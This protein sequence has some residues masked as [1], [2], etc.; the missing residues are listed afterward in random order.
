[1][2]T[3]CH[4]RLFR[5]LV[6][7]IVRFFCKLYEVLLKI[8]TRLRRGLESDPTAILIDHL[9]PGQVKAQAAIDVGLTRPCTDTGE[10]LVLIPFRD[11]WD[12]TQTCLRTL[13]NQHF[14]DGVKVRVV[15]IDNGSVNLE[16]SAGLG[17]VAKNHPTLN[18]KTLQAN[19]EFNYSRL[20][21]DGYRQFKAAETKWVLF[22]NNDVELLDQAILQRMVSAL[23]AVNDVA[24]VG[25]TLLYPNRQIQHLFA[26]PGVKIIAAHPIKGEAFRPSMEWFAKPVRP[27]AAVTGAVM[28]VRAKDFE[29]VGMLDESLATMG[30]DI[31]L[32]LKFYYD[33]GK[34]SATVTY[35]NVIHCESRTKKGNFSQIEIRRM[36]EKWGSKLLAHPFYSKGFSRFSQS[37]LL[38]IGVEPKYPAGWVL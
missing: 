34:F 15:L 26:A 14:N 30:Q 29:A 6:S 18:I 2:F 31:D 9:T 25:C 23:A 13:A 21:N 1:V 4:I 17:E 32:C 20:N 38:V 27:V 3:G 24:A 8:N 37:P 11:R 36:N 16:T 7:F 19:Y 12:L 22:L 33:L 5:T 10:L 28:M 35:C